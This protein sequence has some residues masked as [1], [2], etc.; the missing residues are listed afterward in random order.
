MYAIRPLAVSTCSTKPC[1]HDSKSAGWPL[2]H[3]SS[4]PCSS[5]SGSTHNPYIAAVGAFCDGF[6][7]DEIS[8]PE[9]SCDAS[10]VAS[11]ECVVDLPAPPEVAW[12]FVVERG[13]EIEPLRFEPEGPQ[14][15]GTLN[16]LSGRVLG[17]PIKGLS[18]TVVW[19]PPDRCAFESIRPGWPVRTRIDEQFESQQGGTRHSI[20]YD[21]AP[22]GF[23]GR[24][25]APL[26]CALMRRSRRQY[27][28]RLRT[29]LAEAEH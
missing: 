11:F 18:R 3:T 10:R 4:A 1:C 16:R 9:R 23:V 2:A 6:A 15:V 7:C 21:V 13:A 25:A 17:V 5:P 29:A 28:E 12:A 20:R 24:L 26:V 22:S 8:R 14:G 27:Q 19:Q